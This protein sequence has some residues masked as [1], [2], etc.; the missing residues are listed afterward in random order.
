MRN[1]LILFIKKNCFFFFFF[2]GCVGS[3]LQHTGF[4]VVATSR[5]LLF[6][7]VLRL[8]IVVTSLV[9]EHGLVARGLQ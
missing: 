7:T 1:L 6:I 8:L 9:A 5:G 3:S 2:F 4:P